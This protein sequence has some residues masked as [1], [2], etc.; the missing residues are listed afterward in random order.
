M[1]AHA[2][3]A[4]GEDRHVGAALA[5][6]LELAIDDRLTDLVVRY[7][8]ARRQHLTT[9]MRRDLLVAP[10]LVLTRGG[11]VVAVAINDHR[12][13][14]PAFSADRQCAVPS[15]IARSPR[16]LITTAAPA[17]A[18]ASA[19]ALPMLLPEPVTI[20]TLPSSGLASAIISSAV[21]GAQQ[22]IASGARSTR[23]I[24]PPGGKFGRTA[25]LCAIDCIRIK[26]RNREGAS[27][28][29]A[30]SP[31]RRAV[32]KTAALA[33]TALAAPFVHGA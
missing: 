12:K 14:P 32:L 2:C 21:R 1:M 7:I 17:A 15:M 28:M 16:P 27:P 22:S 3:G 9:G 13:V 26:R 23:P 5:L 18:S 29:T 19:I 25:M 30:T 31:T 33:T 24:R 10:S 4:R 11:G 8:R 6:H 20:A